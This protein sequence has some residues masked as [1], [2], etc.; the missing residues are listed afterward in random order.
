M[1][2]DPAEPAQNARMKPQAGAGAV[3]EGGDVL[4]R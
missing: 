4:R 3:T 1:H 2:A